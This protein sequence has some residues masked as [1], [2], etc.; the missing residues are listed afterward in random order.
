MR[1]YYS[2]LFIYILLSIFLAGCSTEHFELTGTWAGT[3]PDSV[4]QTFIFGDGG[5]VQWIF[6]ETA[7]EDTFNLIYTINYT[8]NPHNFSLAGFNRGY[9]E[10]KMLY[11]ILEFDGEN[12]IRIDMKTAMLGTEGAEVRP[13]GFTS[14]TVMYR[15]ID[16]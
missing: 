12:E 4:A 11:G 7:T 9:L 3:G 8:T 16:E 1:K 14:Q 15:R 10:G 5:N 2:S 6:N 13:V